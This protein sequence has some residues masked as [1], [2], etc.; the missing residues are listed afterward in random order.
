MS[1]TWR[2]EIYED[3]L[4]EEVLNRVK[5]EI[6]IKEAKG[7]DREELIRYEML[8][9][10]NDPVYFIENFLYTDKNP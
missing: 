6:Q 2:T 9:C 7:K 5:R 10:Y 4:L 1:K 8:T 3:L